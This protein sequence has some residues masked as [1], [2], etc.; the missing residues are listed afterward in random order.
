MNEPKKRSKKWL[1]VVFAAVVVLAALILAL[2]VYMPNRGQ[3]A[4]PADANTY[5]GSSEPDIT[6]P[7]GT[8][9]EPQASAKANEPAANAAEADEASAEVEEESDEQAAE[10]TPRD[11]GQVLREIARNASSWGA[12]YQN[13]YGQEAPDFAFTDLEGKSHKLSDYKGRK[14]IIVLWAT[15]CRPC[16][17][18]VPHLIAARNI[19]DPDELSILGVT[20]KG[21]GNPESAIRK[22]VESNKR[23]NYTIVPV[24]RGEI[25][26]PYRSVEYIPSSFFI[27]S[28]GKIVLVS[29]GQMELGSIKAI[30]AAIE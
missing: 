12:E 22:F 5:S 29:T 8:A 7:S 23:I 20:V 24:N 14:V 4:G 25:P 26:E 6:E 28:R 21:P 1:P 10:E 2:M 11:P 15:W 3:S 30:L 19:Y 18:E 9:G 27:D 17:V 16:V 13:W